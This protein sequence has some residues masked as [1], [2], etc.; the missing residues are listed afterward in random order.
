MQLV[1]TGVWSTVAVAGNGLCAL[2]IDRMGRVLALKLGWILS[3]LGVVGI[4][5]SL[6]VYGNTGS[7]SAGIAGVFFIY[8]HIFAYAAFVDPT[9]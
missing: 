9:T 3:G 4:C 8:W 5:I 1:L 7:R 2:F 6:A